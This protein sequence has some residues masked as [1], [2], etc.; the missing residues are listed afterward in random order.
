MA[1]VTGPLRTGRAVAPSLLAAQLAGMLAVRLRDPHVPG[2]WGACPVLELT[3][4]PCPF[5]GSMRAASDLT[6]LDLAAAWSSNAY[7]TVVVIGSLLL[8]LAWVV[9]DAAR[10]AAAGVLPPERTIVTAAVVLLV[11]W[12]VFGAA[13]LHPAL[14]WLQP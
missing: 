11:G 3:G 10:P 7:S 14:A 12:F 6:R 9:R 5:C 2:S 4:L 8:T 13:R 1:A